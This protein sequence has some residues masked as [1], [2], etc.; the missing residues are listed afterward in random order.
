MSRTLPPPPPRNSQRGDRH[1]DKKRR[2]RRG[3]IGHSSNR[4]QLDEDLESMFSSLTIDNIPAE[5]N[6]DCGMDRKRKSYKDQ[7]G[8]ENMI[9]SLAIQEAAVTNSVYRGQ[10]KKFSDLILDDR[11]ILAKGNS[12]CNDP[13]SRSLRSKE[14]IEGIN[15]LLLRHQGS[16]V[17]YFAVHFDLN[18]THAVYLDKWVQFASKSDAKYVTLHLCENGISC[19]RHSV[20]ASRYNFPLHCFGDGRGSLLRK[21]SLTNCIFSTPV[22]SSGFSS[23]VQLSLRRVTTADSDIQN[24][25]SCFPVL[26]DL[27]LQ[28][29]EDLVNIRISHETLLE[30]HISCCQKLKSINIHSI[31]LDI[32]EYDGHQVQIKYEST[33]SMRRIA[34][35]FVDRNCSLPDDLL[36]M[37]RLKKVTLWFLSPSEEPSFILHAKTFTV[38]QLVSL[39]ILPSWNNVL[40]VAYLVKATPSVKRLHLEACSGEHHYLDN[41]QVDW[42]EH[43][44]LKKLRTIL[45]GGFAAQAPLVELLAY[46]SRVAT[47]LKLLEISPH[48]HR[49]KDSGRCVSEDVGVEAAWDHAR[50]A[51]R[52]TIGLKLQST[53][54][55]V[56][57]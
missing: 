3:H 24:I 31:S 55:F 18:S 50:N 8:V 23:L 45:V 33:P 38:L 2:L 46:L 9:S 4:S 34:I 15:D 57:K 44:S 39:S 12:D 25:F 52:A 48:H 5:A 1:D 49:Y 6:S 35:K 10:R 27:K 7:A 29:C 14:F 17:R 32:F 20:T 47:R 51:A 26:R 22:H 19:S 30:L 13:G 16:G 21:L 40:A 53:V 43:I 37:E 41:V 28:C 56:V 54:K 11:K 36:A 42:P